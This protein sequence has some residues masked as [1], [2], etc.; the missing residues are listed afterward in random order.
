MKLLAYTFALPRKQAYAHGQLFQFLKDKGIPDYNQGH[1]LIFVAS[2]SFILIRAAHL[3][4]G[5]PAKEEVVELKNK[6][7][8][9]VLLASLVQKR[10]FKEGESSQQKHINMLEHPEWFNEHILNLF[11]KSGL[12]NIK[13][14]YVVSTPV[15]AVQKFK[16]C[17]IPTVIVDFTAE[18]ENPDLL[19][20]AW[21]NG[22]GRQKTYGL[23]MLRIKADD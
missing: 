11:K 9:Q 19:N 13:Y 8:G 2:E 20:A 21:L 5:I 1:K 16:R 23:G 18:I 22:I 12:K 6:V 4:D 15:Y 10:F 14:D 3:A 17:S 7:K